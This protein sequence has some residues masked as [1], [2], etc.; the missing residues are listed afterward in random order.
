MI[1]PDID[2]PEMNGYE[3]V[4]ILKSK[5]EIYTDAPENLR[6]HE[7]TGRY[8]ITCCWLLSAISKVCVHLLR[9]S[10]LDLYS[11]SSARLIQ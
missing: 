8:V 3:A 1:L 2:M 5:M 10:C 7:K 4:K 6:E 11:I 9:P